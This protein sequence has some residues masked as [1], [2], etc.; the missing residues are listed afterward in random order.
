MMFE[1]SGSNYGLPTQSLGGQP[2]GMYMNMNGDN[3]QGGDN[4]VGANVQSQV[5]V[6]LH[7]ACVV[8]P[9][10]PVFSYTCACAAVCLCV[11]AALKE[12][13]VCGFLLLSYC[14]KLTVSGGK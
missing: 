1:F 4:S 12:A 3:Y 5:G 9:P 7:V 10:P 13:F 8:A 11:P 14:D 2:G 6:G